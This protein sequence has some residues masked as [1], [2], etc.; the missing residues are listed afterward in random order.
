MHR[1]IQHT[2]EQRLMQAYRSV[3]IGN[4]LDRATLMGPLIDE[5]AVEKM[6]TAIARLKSEGGE[7]LLGG[8]RLSGDDY[9]GNC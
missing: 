4:P 7:V 3:K 1:S 9:P 6:M 5:I 8:E 2:L